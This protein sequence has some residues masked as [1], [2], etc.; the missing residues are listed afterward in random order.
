[1]LHLVLEEGLGVA[2]SPLPQSLQSHSIWQMHRVNL[3]LLLF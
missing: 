3:A 2:F 1:M